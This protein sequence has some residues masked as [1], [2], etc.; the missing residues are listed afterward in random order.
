M[1]LPLPPSPR[2]PLHLA[3]SPLPMFHPALPPY[4]QPY[5]H[6][7][8]HFSKQSTSWVLL[9][10]F[11][12]IHRSLNHHH[13]IPLHS[14]ERTSYVPSPFPLPIFLPNNITSHT[15]YHFS[16]LHHSPT[17]PLSTDPSYGVSTHFAFSP[18]L[19]SLSPWK[20]PTGTPLINNVSPTGLHSMKT[21]L[22]HI[23][24]HFLITISLQM[25]LFT[26]HSTMNF[27]FHPIN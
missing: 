26:W 14:P 8:N 20:G 22:R 5:Y 2:N 11:L 23:I 25:L 9:D 10:L 18:L 13:L 6:V 17:S 3:Q 21:V 19:H 24:P 27:Q 16:H 1:F 12:S 4:H 7:I 15:P